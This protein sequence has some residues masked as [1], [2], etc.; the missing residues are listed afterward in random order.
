MQRYRVETEFYVAS[1]PVIAAARATQRGT[2]PAQAQID[3][4]LALVGDANRGGYGESVALGI[5]RLREASAFWRGE[6]SGTPDL[7]QSVRWRPAYG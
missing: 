3:A 4:A 1:D 6:V 7:K 5:R 2:P